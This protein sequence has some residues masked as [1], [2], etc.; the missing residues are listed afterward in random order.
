MTILLVALLIARSSLFVTV[1]QEIGVPF[2]TDAGQ[3]LSVLK[4]I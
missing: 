2:I 1:L 3:I 4:N